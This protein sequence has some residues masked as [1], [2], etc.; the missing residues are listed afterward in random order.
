MEVCR[1]TTELARGG[2]R[3]KALKNELIRASAGTGKTH[4]LVARYLWLLENGAEP[5]RIA[6]M[7]FT[8]KAAGEFFERILR[9]LAERCGEA[10]GGAVALGMLRK[11]VSR[12]DKLRLGTI[13]G[14]F[15]AMTQC[16]PFELGLTGQTALMS[17]EDAKQARE[18]V[19][20][21]LMLAVTRLEK[22]GALD[23]LREAWKAASHGHEQNRP[24]D[25]LMTWCSRLHELFIEC[26]DAARW[27]GEAAIWP[28]G[29]DALKLADG[30]LGAA[31]AKLEGALDMP[32][33]EKRAQKKWDE[34]FEEVPN[35]K[36]AEKFDKSVVGYMLSP[37]RGAHDKL[38][39]DSIEWKMWKNT[40]L[41]R[42]AGSA[43]ADVLDMLMGR[44]LRSHCQRTRAQFDVMRLYEAS[45]H[46]LAR[47]RGRL[48]F[49]DLGSLLCGRVR[50]CPTVDLEEMRT[51]LE[52]R[53]DAKYDHWLL[54]EFQD[55]SERQWDVLSPLLEE[56][57]QDAENRR[58]VFLVGDLKQSIYLWRQ[59]EPELFQHVERA[60]DGE[61]LTITP[62]NE[63][64][65]SCEQ[66]LEMVNAVFLKAEPLLDAMF[67]GVTD[68]WRYERH[69]CSAK[70]ASLRGHAAL[71][72]VTKDEDA[73]DEGNP[74]VDAVAA[75]IR[76][77]NPPAR[78]LTCAVLVRKND[79]ARAMS[80]ALRAALGMEVICES[81]EAVCVDNPA[82]L[83]LLSLVQLAAHPGDTK[84][85]EHL[86]MTPLG[87][88]LRAECMERALLSARLRMDFSALGFLAVLRDWA[89]RLRCEMVDC[90]AF[91]ERRLAQ[92]LDFAADYDESGS[93]DLDDF[94]RRAREHTVREETASARAIQV[95]TVHQ[96][97]GL[98]FDIVILPE[99]QGEALNS[100]TRNRLFVAR[101]ERGRV[102]WVLDKPEKLVI[103]RDEVLDAAQDH[104]KA[105]QAFEG[106]CR[107][108]VAMTRAELGLY[109]F[110]TEPKRKTNGN[111][112]DLLTQRLGVADSATYEVGA[113]ACKTV[114]EHGERDWFSAHALKIEPEESATD[115]RV[116]GAL[117]SLLRKVN[118][119]LQRRAPSGEEAFL[120]TGSEFASPMREV[121][122]QLGLR[123]H[124][125]FAAIRWLDEVKDATSAWKAAALEAGDGAAEL[126]LRALGVDD[127]RQYFIRGT[128][129]REVW[130]ERRFDLADDQEWISGIFDRVVLERNGAGGWTR[131]TILD[132]KTDDVRDEDALRERA[133]SYAPQMK[134]YR[135]AAARLT[136]LSSCEIRVGL[137]FCTLGQ[138]FWG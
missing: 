93:R 84:A 73:E 34:F 51:A 26:P 37:D 43:L 12:M 77:L 70:V 78:G 121:K 61:R 21:A 79:T 24:T 106:L 46:R 40:L 99:L 49:S 15:A 90:D 18:E 17:E 58:S 71:L 3:V 135:Q 126:C 4:S 66:V 128:A 28:K 32:A 131:A 83:A 36:G 16:L 119:S 2:G 88:G 98:Q 103:E 122:R 52:F 75:L 1:S 85:W 62:L 39:L 133:A 67:P 101:G 130:I 80:E 137:V 59:A 68:L 38:R 69:V 91:T 120:L 41:S 55:T 31:L 92:L 6:A 104:E 8:R 82:T 27:G 107:L 76:E 29:S 25:A 19:L 132:F 100:V 35:R 89:E 114:W 96:S 13:D 54:D 45:Y 87:E 86:G 136:G 57:R 23:E 102:D 44:V 124:E 116:V 30:D 11:V 48:V 81:Q 138:V 97:K 7:T 72:K 65:R 53:M 112:A 108:Y 63:S 56:A 42:S 111:E 5:E 115:S 109:A 10:E 20:D 9:K 123:V 22:Q 94:L 110:V 125:L 60:W 50:S 14:F 113:L 129:D 105:R 47:G 95:M 33:F 118:I 134:L 127:V 117:G 74:L 64:Y